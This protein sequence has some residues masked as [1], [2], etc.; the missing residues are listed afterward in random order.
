MMSVIALGLATAGC[1]GGAQEAKEPMATETAPPEI[2]MKLFFKNP[3]KATFRISPDGNFISYR[4]PWHNRMNLFVR[5]IGDTSV[6]QVTH[7]TI[8]DVGGYFW[9]GDRLLYARDIN[10]DE[11]FIVFSASRDGQDVKPLTPEHGVRAGIIDDLKDVAGMER[12]VIIQMN[13]RNP[14]VF[15]PYLVNIET[16]KMEQLVDNKDNYESWMTDHD[17]VI[18]IATKSDG[19]TNKVFYRPNAT[20][21]FKELMTVDF[22]DAWAPLFFTF[23]NKNLYVSSNLGGRDK[24]AIVEWDIAANKEVREIFS[25][26]D[27]DVDGLDFSRKRKVLTSVS[28][29]SWKPEEVYLDDE[30]K[31][32]MATLRAKIPGYE[33]FIA[34]ENDNEDKFMVFASSDRMPGKYYF[35]DSATSDLKEMATLYPWLK[36][37]DLAEMKP[38]SYPTRDGL[39]VHGYLTL[40]KGRAD[41]DLP[42]V[43]VVHGGPWARDVWGYDPEAQFLANRGYAVLQVNYRGSTGYGRKFWEASFKKWGKEM[44][45]DVTDGVEWLKKEGIA[46]PDRVAIYGG[47]YGGYATLAGVTFTPDLYACGVDYVGVS[48]LFTF[49]NTIPPYWKPFLDMMHAMVGDPATDST[50]MAEASPVFHADRITCPLFIAQGANDPRVNKDE[51]DQMVEA[52]RKRGVEVQYMVKDNEGHG[53][54][55]E[56]NRFD[57]YGAMEAFLGAHIGEKPSPVKG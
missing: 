27:Y 7:D 42:V 53:F 47:S 4:A 56:E 54:H 3:D 30:T 28:Y 57:F 17:G 11:N 5:P 55:N 8:R 26:P 37:N 22:K 15:D 51:S 49:M 13:Q 24:T 1:S 33:L 6:V 46:D 52:L 36:E 21:P 2:D 20:T 10:G 29:T 48:N 45:N 23:D 34:G 18:R 31:A 25:N 39:T 35:Y 38:V 50:L 12:S 41:K 19:V 9:K 44:Q 16:G 43:M 40:P 32:M 14:Q